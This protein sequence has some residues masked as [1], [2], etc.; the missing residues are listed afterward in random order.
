MNPSLTC[1][2][3]RAGTSL[4]EVQT[5]RTFRRHHLQVAHPSD[6]RGPRQFHRTRQRHLGGATSKRRSFNTL[7]TNSVALLAQSSIVFAAYVAEASY[8]VKWQCVMFSISTVISPPSKSMMRSPTVRLA[9]GMR[10]VPLGSRR[11]TTPAEVRRCMQSC[12]RR[13]CSKFTH[14]TP[15][16]GKY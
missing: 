11:K 7:S 1:V 5:T 14:P 15:P 13:D 8:G 6:A 9:A 4:W 12:S 10:M 16:S 3:V 2:D